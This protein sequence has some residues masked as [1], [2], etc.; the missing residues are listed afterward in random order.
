M[1]TTFPVDL[2][3]TATAGDTRY[4]TPS[5][6]RSPNDQERHNHRYEPCR[7][8]AQV[9]ERPEVSTST[10]GGFL[11]AGETEGK[12]RMGKTGYGGDRDPAPGAKE[13]RGGGASLTRETAAR[14][15][16]RAVRGGGKGECRA[17]EGRPARG[18]CPTPSGPQRGAPK[19]RPA[20]GGAGGVPAEV[21][22]A[23]DGFEDR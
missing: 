4:P 8:G 6:C 15:T 21:V 14:G 22:G 18:A 2:N 12:T 1:L 20:T 9:R 3:P 19:G 5:P 10:H 7:K 23:V 17:R 16:S 11:E 13:A